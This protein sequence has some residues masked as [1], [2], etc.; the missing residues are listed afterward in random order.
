M[1]SCEVGEI[2][3]SLSRTVQLREYH[4]VTMKLDVT[5]IPGID[6]DP[7]I[8]I[9]EG[10]AWLESQVDANMSAYLTKL[11]S[12]PASR[13]GMSKKPQAN[14]LNLGTRRG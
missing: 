9:N 8:V 2:R 3:L 11:Q 10:Y 7:D 13:A 4:P 5:L 12:E 14:P 6:S 1:S